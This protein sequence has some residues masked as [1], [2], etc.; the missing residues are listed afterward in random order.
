MSS[1]FRLAL[2]GLTAAALIGGVM[3]ADPADAW[4]KKKHK[5]VKVVKVKKVKKG[6]SVKQVSN[7]GNA[8]AGNGGN[9][10]SGGSSGNVYNTGNLGTGPVIGPPTGP[11]VGVSPAALDCAADVLV[12]PGGPFTAAQIANALTTVQ[13]A[14]PVPCFPGVVPPAFLDCLV[15]ASATGPGITIDEVGDCG[16]VTPGGVIAPGTPGGSVFSGNGGAGAAGGAGGDAFGGTGG[17]NSNTSTV[18]VT[19]DDHSIDVDN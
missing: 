13:P 9:G 5:K 10:G 16:E 1:K 17:N 6:N 2:A 12:G 14:A 18:T 7:G 4:K 15:A 8:K 3:T 11:G 19:R